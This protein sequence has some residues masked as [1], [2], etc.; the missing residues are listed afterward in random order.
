MGCGSWVMGGCG[1]NTNFT[2]YTSI[3]PIIGLWAVGRGSG[4]WVMGGCG[5]NTTINRQKHSLNAF[6][7]NSISFGLELQH[8]NNVFRSAV[9]G[10]YDPN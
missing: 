2:L 1:G 9:L 7:S 4:L 3:T 5:S 10:C 8:E 6:G